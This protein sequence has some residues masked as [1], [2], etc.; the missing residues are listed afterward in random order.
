MLLLFILFYSFTIDATVIRYSFFRDQLTKNNILPI[1]IYDSYLTG[2]FK[3]PPELPA[4]E[5]EGS[6]PL[7][8]GS[9]TPKK[10][11]KN[12]VVYLPT[13]ISSRSELSKLL[14]EVRGEKGFEGL[15]TS[16]CQAI[17]QDGSR[18]S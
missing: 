12:F 17:L 1:Q 16:T 13:D 18:S 8:R 14:E 9:T 3:I 11:K 6:N 5:V 4:D 7:S 10:A 2:S 15:V